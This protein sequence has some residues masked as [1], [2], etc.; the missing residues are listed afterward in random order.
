M[1]MCR[2]VFQYP[3]V[4]SSEFMELDHSIKFRF[5]SGITAISRE[6]RVTHLVGQSTAKVYLSSDRKMVIKN[7][8]HRASLRDVQFEILVSEFF[9]EQGLMVSEIVDYSSNIFSI[10]SF[11]PEDSFYVVKKYHFGLTK[12]QRQEQGTE[13]LFE[14]DAPM[15]IELYESHMKDF[16]GWLSNDV[17][18]Q[19][20]LVEGKPRHLDSVSENWLL[21]KEGW[22]FID[23]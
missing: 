21:T 22:V 13:D 17:R 19:L 14:K 3:V 7:Y 5:T 2:T 23:P 11:K 1:R 9:R 10:K 20:F 8:R 6:V 16:V 18:G 15:L 12:K 4:L